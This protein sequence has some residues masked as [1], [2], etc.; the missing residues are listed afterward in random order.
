MAVG[1]RIV[2][3]VAAAAR[4]RALAVDGGEVLERDGL[5]LAL[6]NLPDP[7]LNGIYV[8]R[9]PED[10][11]A[12]LSWAA[13]ETAERGHPFGIDLAAAR[14]PALADAVAALGLR[15]VESRPAMA[16]DPAGLAPVGPPPGVEIRRV[17][18]QADALALALVDAAAWDGD[19]EHSFRA[20]ANGA[21]ADGVDAFVAWEGP[22]ALG[23]VIAY[24]HAGSIGIFGLGVVPDA[25]RRGLGRALTSAGAASSPADLVWLFP[26]PMAES[27]YLRT[28]FEALETWEIWVSARP[29][30]P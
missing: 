18:T 14:F 9:E 10:A 20:Y 22:R 5:V 2:A 17:A 15:R 24:R 19:A 3:G 16:A 29:R 30:R 8:E 21:L 13:S 7:A 28:G 1:D 12:T 23:C 4:T 27:L 26:T 25:R 11:K 6:T